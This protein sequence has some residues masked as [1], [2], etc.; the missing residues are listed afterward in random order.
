MA[1]FFLF[2]SFKYIYFLIFFPHKGSIVFF[3]QLSF[4]I[5]FEFNYFLSL[6][7]M[8]TIILLFEFYH[9]YKKKKRKKVL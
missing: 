2:K 3:Y 4:H 1:N 6:I 8:H 7:F 9:T 5:L